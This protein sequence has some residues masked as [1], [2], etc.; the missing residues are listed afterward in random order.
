M[1]EILMRTIRT[2]TC[3]YRLSHVTHPTYTRFQPHPYLSRVPITLRY[4]FTFILFLIALTHTFS[5]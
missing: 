5:S 3:S 1:L 4:V 2:L